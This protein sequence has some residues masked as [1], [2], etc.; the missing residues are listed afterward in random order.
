MTNADGNQ[1]NT[2]LQVTCTVLL[3]LLI[4]KDQNGRCFDNWV[5]TSSLP[6]AA[7]R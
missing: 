7:H 6:V 5:T 1:Q 4:E 3:V 2:R